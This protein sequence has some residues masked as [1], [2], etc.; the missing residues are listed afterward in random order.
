[1]D[2][3]ELEMLIEMKTDIASIKTSLS[4][5]ETANATANEALQSTKSAHRRLD[6]IDKI[7]FWTVTTIIGAVIVALLSSLWVVSH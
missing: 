3:K 2:E 5:M 1:M 7:I 4:G 6:K